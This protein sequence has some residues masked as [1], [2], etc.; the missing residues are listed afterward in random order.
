[1]SIELFFA[2]TTFIIT[3]LMLA[4]IGVAICY[5][6]FEYKRNFII[7]EAILGA[8]I[9]IFGATF[10]SINVKFLHPEQINT[11]IITTMIVPDSETYK[12]GTILNNVHLTFVTSD[13]HKNIELIPDYTDIEIIDD[14]QRET[15]EKT[16]YTYLFIKK[17]TDKLYITKDTYNRLFN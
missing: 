7:T 10:G 17:Q 14:N 16:I 8:F 11:T 6:V 12:P 9:I 4:V 2:I 3:I 15:Y 1:M 5:R 13:N